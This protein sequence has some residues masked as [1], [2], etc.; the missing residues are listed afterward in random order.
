LGSAGLILIDANIFIYAAGTRHPHKAPSV[1]LLDRIAPGEIEAPVD[2]EAWREI[3]HRY[4]A[5]RPGRT[6]GRSVP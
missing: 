2:A 4:P 6:A 5:V 1:A 3:L